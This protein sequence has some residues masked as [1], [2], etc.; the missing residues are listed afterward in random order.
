[1]PDGTLETRSITDVNSNVMT[2]ST[3]FSQTPNA[4]A[5]YI[6]ETTSLPSQTWRVI[7][8]AENDNKTFIEKITGRIHRLELHRG[9]ESTKKDM[10][11]IIQNG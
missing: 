6:L 4:N 2:V 5:P 3:A 1:M 11:K 8:I 10:S 7:S 9:R